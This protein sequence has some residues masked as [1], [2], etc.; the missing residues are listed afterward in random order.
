MRGLHG[1]FDEVILHGDWEISVR[2][3]GAVKQAK[4]Y[5]TP[6]IRDALIDLLQHPSREVRLAAAGGLVS[7]QDPTAI[8]ALQQAMED[9]YNPREVMDAVKSAIRQLERIAQAPVPDVEP[10]LLRGELEQAAQ[11]KRA[12]VEL[13]QRL[14]AALKDPSPKVRNHAAKALGELGD[15]RAVPALLPM[16]QD[17]VPGVRRAVAVALGALK[18]RQAVPALMQYVEASTDIFREM[19]A[20]YALRDIGDPRALPAVLH[21]MERGPFH[22]AGIYHQFDIIPALVTHETLP[23]LK[24]SMARMERDYRARPPRRWHGD[25]VSPEWDIV[26]VA[27]RHIYSAALA[28]VAEA[29]DVPELLA[30]FERDLQGPG[31]EAALARLADPVMLEPMRR[32]LLAGHLNAIGVLAAL[33]HAGMAVLKEALHSP[34]AEVRNAVSLFLFNGEGAPVLQQLVDEE[35]LQLLDELAAH[36]PSSMVR[37]YAKAGRHPLPQTADLA[38]SRLADV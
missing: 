11:D 25:K 22:I 21:A 26:E 12:R 37:M 8:P 16:L 28:R 9:T 15:K 29:R 30:A 6:E 20:V 13:M 14:I 24:E 31:L 17:P 36:D 18:S 38:A 4:R 19:T 10:R 35:L 23:L 5:H 34:L 1:E 2:I 33:G 7:Q 32:H 3:R 27:V